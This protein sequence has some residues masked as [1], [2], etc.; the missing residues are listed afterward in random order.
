MVQ[1]I[2]QLI[3]LNYQTCHLNQASSQNTI[4]NTLNSHRDAQIPQ[5]AKDGLSPQLT[6]DYISSISKSHMN[7]GMT[8]LFQMGIQTLGTPITHRPYSIPLTCQKF[9]NKEIRLLENSGCI[10]IS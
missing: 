4:Q 1:M 7:V 2:E 6:G 9:I 3:T 5:E 8:N 10:S